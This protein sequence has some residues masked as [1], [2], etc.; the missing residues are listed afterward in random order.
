[1]AAYLGVDW[2]GSSWVV[3][4]AGDE[5]DVTTEPSFL[6]VWHEL[7]K[8]EDVAAILVDIPIG[9]P[10]SGPRACDEEAATFR[11]TSS[12][13]VFSV[14]GRSIVYEEDYDEAKEACESSLGSQSWWLLPRIQ[15]VD[16]FL[17]RHPDALDKVYESHP[18][19]CFASLTDG[20]LPGKHSENGLDD[21]IDLLEDDTE[22]HEKIKSTI[23]NRRNGTEWHER[24]SSGRLDDVVDA[25]VLAYTA[26]RIGLSSRSDEAEYPS[27]PEDSEPDEDTTLNIYPEI[28]YPK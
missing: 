1:M 21:R 25:A 3:V 18:E 4:K 5:T 15:E 20:S 12:N 8:C 28:L 23:D 2:A 24:I 9:L 7:G 16:V 26:K 6:N 19:I 17:Q 27:L 11:G 22:L 10:D 14:P 13:T